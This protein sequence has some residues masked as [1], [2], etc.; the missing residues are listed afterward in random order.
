ML[1]DHRDMPFSIFHVS[2]QGNPMLRKIISIKNVGRFLS[3]SA[4]GDVELK[5]YSL[6]FAENRGG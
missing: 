3:Y 5:H 1:K 2:W 4:G 6:V